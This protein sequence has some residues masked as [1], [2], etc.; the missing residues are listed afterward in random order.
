MLLVGWKNIIPN[1]GLMREDWVIAPTI[2]DNYSYLILQENL[3]LTFKAPV[4]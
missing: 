4:I 3:A 1:N 2:G